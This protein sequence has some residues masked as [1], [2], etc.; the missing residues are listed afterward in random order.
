VVEDAE[1]GLAGARAAGMAAIGVGE[2]SVLP[3]ADLVV[4]SLLDIDVVH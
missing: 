3:S 1:S 2:P 4:R